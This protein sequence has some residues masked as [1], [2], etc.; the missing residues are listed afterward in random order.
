A[1]IAASA[2]PRA[3]ARSLSEDR[4]MLQSVAQR[5]ARAAQPFCRA[6]L[7]RDCAF[8]IALVEAREANAYASGRDDI[9]VTTGM[10]R[11]LANE[12]ELAA[13][14]AH[15][16][17][18]HIAGHIAE[19]T[20]RTQAGAMAGSLI[21][22][23]AGGV[24]RETLG[25]DVGLSRLGAQAGAT[26]GR[27]TYSKTDEREADYLGA[28][29][30]AR[31]G[32]DLERGGGL[33]AKLTALSGHERTALLDTHPAGPERLAAWRRT[34]EEIRANPEAPPRRDR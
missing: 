20:L 11:L 23:V 2:P 32:F 28:H 19:G 15:E 10:M 8:R 6:E 14:V 1:E 34:A 3:N 27:L 7:G 17:A 18:H 29:I 26:A 13:V 25:V 31:A 22:A 12:D 24:L 9:A 21:G 4:A 30:M 5:L 33:W 16:M